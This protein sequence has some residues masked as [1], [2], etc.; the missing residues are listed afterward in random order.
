MKRQ[1]V[2]LGLLLALVMVN[3]VFAQ[4][5][6]AEHPVGDV[7]VLCPRQQAPQAIIRAAQLFVSFTG[8]DDRIVIP[9]ARV[10]GDTMQVT[11]IVLDCTTDAA[12]IASQIE[13]SPS[14]EIN[15]VAPRPANEPG[16][17][18]A[19]AGYLIVNTS[20]A[21]LRSCGA[22]TCTRV[23][24]V[25]GGS[26]L[27]VLGR[28]GDD[29]WWFVQ[30]GDYR[31]WIAAS[32]VIARGDLSDV[33]LVATQGERTP[34]TVYIGYPGNPIYNALMPGSAVICGVEGG[35]E[36]ALIGRNEDTTW[37]LIEAV[38]LDGTPA[39]GWIDAQFVAIR[40]T[41]MVEVPVVR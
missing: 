32:V 29:S 16:V 33:P 10:N 25:D 12:A 11:Q 23:A 4:Q 34:P 15:E 24:V 6:V 20:A 28:N 26:S 9:V 38:C 40:N 41:G 31:G 2:F 35:R 36:F 8:S 22:A 17:A 39:T 27:V 1:V 19:Q 3:P 18:E 7:I 14:L 13:R 5:P 37:L 21:N 30:A